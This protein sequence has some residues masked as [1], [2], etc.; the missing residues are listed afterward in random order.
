MT[1]S[2]KLTSL[3]GMESDN[4]PTNLTELRRMCPRLFKKLWDKA[5]EQGHYAGIQA[6]HE[7]ERENREFK[8]RL[9]EEKGIL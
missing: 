7:V 9:L 6:V 8:L 4:M 2:N 5:Y 1:E 3:S